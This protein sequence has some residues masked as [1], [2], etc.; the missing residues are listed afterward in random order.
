[1]LAKAMRWSVLRLACRSNA[2][3]KRSNPPE[4]HNLQATIEAQIVT[5]TQF[6][7]LSER[8]LLPKTNSLR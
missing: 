7:P 5:N 6:D 3:G 8:R 4:K 2:V 1:M